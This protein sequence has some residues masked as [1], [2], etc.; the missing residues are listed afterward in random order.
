MSS[1]VVGLTKWRRQ[2]HEGAVR[3][4]CETEVD[5][6]SNGSAEPWRRDEG[7]T[8]EGSCTVASGSSLNAFSGSIVA[9]E[10]RARESDAVRGGVGNRTENGADRKSLGAGI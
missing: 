1:A 5:G 6:D 4:G 2:L 7:D 8:S 3:G 9:A 10:K